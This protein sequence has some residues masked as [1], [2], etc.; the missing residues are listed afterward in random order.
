MTE[1]INLFPGHDT[2]LIVIT[3]FAGDPAHTDVAI[4]FRLPLLNDFAPIGDPIANPLKELRHVGA[5]GR[6]V[7]KMGTF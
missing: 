3:S 5:G 7:M 6:V 2:G 4:L 1:S